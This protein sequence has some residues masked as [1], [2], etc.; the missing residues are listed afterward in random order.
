MDHAH[1]KKPTCEEVLR[2]QGMFPRLDYLMCET[3]LMSSEEEITRL[4]KNNLDAPVNT[5]ETDD[6]E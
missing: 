5:R 1:Q 4:A 2:L 3:L 6:Q